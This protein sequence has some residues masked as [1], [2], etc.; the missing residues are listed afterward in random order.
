MAITKEEI[1]VRGAELGDLIRRVIH[2]GNVRRVIIR[3]ARGR[4]VLEIPVTLGVV[5]FVTAPMLTAVGTL[6]ALAIEWT[7]VIERDE[8]RDATGA[9][10]KA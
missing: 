2:E 8:Q 6:A 10:R 3:D 9:A 7:I 5:A 1:R 4:T